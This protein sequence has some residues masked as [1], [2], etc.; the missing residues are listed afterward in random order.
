MDDEA[1]AYGRKLE[2]FRHYL[3]LLA[4]LQLDPRLRGKLD[5]SDVVQQTLLEAYQKRD[6]FR[7]ASEG[8]WVAWLRQVLARNLAD[9]LR[10]FSQAKRDV[11][12]ECSLDEAL[13]VSSARLE[14]WL[15]AEGSSPSG[16]A[17]RHERAVRLANALAALPEAQREALVLQHW[18]GWKLAQ[19]ARHLGRS[20]AAVAGLLKRGLRQLRQHVHEPE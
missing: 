15:A 19:I 8:E 10:A 18:H 4:R 11:S 20:Q 13:Q 12:R 17:E 5:P 6:Q 16:Q 3:R 2:R 9:A 7:G 14:G 1:E